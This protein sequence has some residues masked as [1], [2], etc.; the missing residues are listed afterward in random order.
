MRV[1]SDCCA[2]AAA[3]F[4]GIEGHCDVDVAMLRGILRDISGRRRM[5]GKQQ[6]SDDE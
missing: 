6:E 2:R 5:S 3:L 4:A 1:N